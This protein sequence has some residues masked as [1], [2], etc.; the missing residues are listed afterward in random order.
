[1]RGDEARLDLTDLDALLTSQTRLVALTAASNALGTL[2]DLT[3]ISARVYAAGAHL[4][5]D[6]VHYAPH[7]LPDVQ[8]WGADLL[9][10]SPYKV[11]G[12]HLGVL[13]LS[14]DMLGTLA[15]PKLAFLGDAAPITWEPGTQNHEAIVG[16]GGT[17]G[18]LD[19]VARQLGG[20][21]SGRA[22][23]ARVFVAFAKHETVLFEGLLNGLDDL[24]ATRYGLRGVDGRTA[25]VSFNLGSHAP[26]DVVK[27]L[28]AARFSMWWRGSSPLSCSPGRATSSTG[29]PS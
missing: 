20:D 10:F 29:T 19:E 8:A 28:A 25:T 21:G 13:Y 4:M 11:F 1:M 15:A 18:Y 27:H 26:Q 16:F 17:F 24:G 6:A 3:V 23:W 12:P 7:G 22:A 14:P 5:V 9:V 2:P